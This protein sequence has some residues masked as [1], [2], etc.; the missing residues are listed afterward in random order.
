MTKTGE[1]LR[2]S[3]LANLRVFKEEEGEAQEEEDEE[4]E[5][6]EEERQPRQSLR[7][8]PLLAALP[9]P[10]PWCACDEAARPGGAACKVVEEPDAADEPFGPK[11]PGTPTVH[12]FLLSRGH[13]TCGIS[14]PSDPTPRQLRRQV[15]SVAVPGDPGSSF[16][17][18]VRVA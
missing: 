15:H 2:P 16:T 7:P 18:E 1:P 6:E 13:G 9:I 4:D 3:S 5:D 17:G 12:S 11:L 8:K 10:I 14:A